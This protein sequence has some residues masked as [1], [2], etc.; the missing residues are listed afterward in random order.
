MGKRFISFLGTNNYLETRYQY[1]EYV[2]E[3]VRFVQEA[4]IGLLCRNWRESDSIIIFCTKDSYAKNWVDNGQE[5][6]TTEVEKQGLESRLSKLGLKAKVSEQ[7]IPEGFTEDAMWEI[8]NRV[9]NSLG[10]NDEIYLD[11]THAFRSIPL[12]TIPLFNFAKFMKGTKVAAIYYGA[13]EALG[14]IP[15]VVGMPVDDRI[16][17]IVELSSLVKL[18]ATNVAASN[19]IDFGKV[20]SINFT[21]DNNTDRSAINAVKEVKQQLELLDYLILTCNME[22]LRDGEYYKAIS[23]RIDEVCALKDVREAEKQL[24]RK[25]LDDLRSRGFSLEAS[26]NNI[27]SAARWAINHNMIQQAYTLGEEFMLYKIGDYLYDEFNDNVS[28]KNKGNK[29]ALDGFV[30][31]VLAVIGTTKQFQIKTNSEQLSQDEITRLTSYY[32]F[33]LKTDEN[34]KEI[35]EYYHAIRVTRNNLNHANETEGSAATAN[36]AMANLRNN[37]KDNFDAFLKIFPAQ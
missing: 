26:E 5:R 13:F 22:R 19:F 20:G 2:S 31:S 3:P 27:V 36:Q 28:E 24:L 18:Q 12:F 21:I 14:A 33:D 11:V 25:I 35:K 4:L 34:I 29:K 17:P 6:A 1:G 32:Q 8:F 37:F 23:E 10:D 7:E 30:R 9:Y 15:K 16:A